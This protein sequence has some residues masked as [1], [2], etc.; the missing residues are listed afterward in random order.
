V[1]GI[2]DEWGR[3]SG[4]AQQDEAEFTQVF[5]ELFPVA[6]RVGFRLL[7]NRQAAEDVAAEALSRAFAR[8]RTL[9]TATYRDAWVIRV[10]TNLSLNVLA[11]R[12]VEASPHEP[13]TVE[14]AAATRIALV[15]A[16]KSLPRRQREI[17]VLRHLA[18]FSEEDI[19]A[20]LGIRAGTVKTHTKRAVAALRRHLGDDFADI[21]D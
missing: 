13:V 4:R 21:D 14:D 5:I 18:D 2:S 15:E 19:A 1:T 8:W 20:T 12:K 17:I 7:G 6:V 16:I 10:T 9:R 11:R 3:I